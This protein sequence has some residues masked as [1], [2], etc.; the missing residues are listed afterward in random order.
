MPKPATARYDALDASGQKNGISEPSS[1]GILCCRVDS[2]STG[3]D[4]PSGHAEATVRIS[5]SRCGHAPNPS[6]SIDIDAEGWRG[7]GEGEKQSAC[8]ILFDLF[9]KK[10]SSCELG[11]CR[12]GNSPFVIGLKALSFPSH[13]IWMRW[14]GRGG[15]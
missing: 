10:I 1:I 8:S 7:Q 13:S 11:Y 3:C 4:S 12:R 14:R 5:L 9:C 2:S 15:G 6:P